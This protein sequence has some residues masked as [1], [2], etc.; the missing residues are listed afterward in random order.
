MGL[1][2]KQNKEKFAPVPEGVHHAV[3]FAIY[4]LGT[5]HD[6]KF[7][8]DVHSVQIMWEL[9]NEKLDNGASR[10]VSKKYTLSLGE[11][12]NLRK[13]LQS[14]RGRAF[15]PDE[16]EGFELKNLLT[17]NAMLQIIHTKKDDNIYAN[18]T[19]ILPLYK[20]MDKLAP[21]IPMAFFSMQDNDSIPEGT[22]GWIE[23]LIRSSSEWLI[24]TEGEFSPAE[25]TQNVPPPT[26][27]PF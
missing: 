23:D 22:P 20:G 7:D 17:V 11:K 14:W 4:D 26:D 6:P 9:P 15:T 19:S 27:V 2:V 13:D 8:K 1:T 16:L 21:T 10:I 25:D 24:S 12:A 5:H 18:I 3:C